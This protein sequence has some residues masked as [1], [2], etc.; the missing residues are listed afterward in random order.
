VLLDHGAVRYLA[1]KL[2]RR[3]SNPL[4]S[5]Y[6]PDGSPFALAAINDP[7][8]GLA[9]A[10]CPLPT[11]RSA[12]SAW[13]ESEWTRTPDSHRVRSVLQTVLPSA[14]PRRRGHVRA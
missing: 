8:A 4:S 9:P 11:D 2:Q 5:G 13:M 1:A 14:G 3:E 7:S 6:E 12:V 10:L